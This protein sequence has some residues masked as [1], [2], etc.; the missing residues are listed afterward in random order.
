MEVLPGN[1]AVWDLLMQCR[2][3]WRVGFGGVYAIDLAA[4]I[5]AARCCGIVPDGGFLEKVGI[6]EGEVLRALRRKEASG[7]CSEEKRKECEAVF[8]KEFLAWACKNCEEMKGKR[9]GRE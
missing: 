7:P 1:T 8:G 9:N 3:Q 6:F 2:T 5:E 4:V